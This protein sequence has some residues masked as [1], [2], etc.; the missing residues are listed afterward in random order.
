MA[1]SMGTKI[2]PAKRAKELGAKSLNQVA[3]SY[4]CSIQN[5]SHKYKTKPNQFDIIVLGAIASIE[6]GVTL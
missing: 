4:G 2:T 6:K 1:Y 5:L 3:H